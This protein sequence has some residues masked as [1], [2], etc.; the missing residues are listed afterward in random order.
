MDTVIADRARS[1]RAEKP[2]G[3]GLYIVPI[4]GS[5][6]DLPDCRILDTQTLPQAR[7]T[8]VSEH[9]QVGDSAGMSRLR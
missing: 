9:E 2:Q 3:R 6:H 4:L 1:V 5:S 8:D 7:A